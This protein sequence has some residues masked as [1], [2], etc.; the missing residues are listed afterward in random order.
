MNS[1]KYVPGCCN[2]GEKE[3]KVRQKFLLA[4]LLFTALLTA[5]AHLFHATWMIYVL[6]FCTL[7]TI[8]LFVEVT[9]RFCVLFG[10]FSLH[11]FNELGHLE[12]VEDGRCKKKDRIKAIY[13]VAGAALLALPY[14]W[15]VFKVACCPST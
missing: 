10:V 5:A 7:S 11:N 4:F 1:D 15:F 3:I 2:I 9:T 6:Y 13:I 12:N 14:A 8:V